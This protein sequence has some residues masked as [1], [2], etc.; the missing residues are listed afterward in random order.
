MG[1]LVP[2]NLEKM[3]RREKLPV[4][5][6]QA[7]MNESVMCLYWLPTTHP[8]EGCSRVSVES[9]QGGQ[10]QLQSHSHAP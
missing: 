6:H 10:A 5:Q 8:V 2:L 3:C 7:K 4:F 1:N 9:F